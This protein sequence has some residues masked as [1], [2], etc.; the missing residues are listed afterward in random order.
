MPIIFKTEILFFTTKHFF[1]FL[2][3]KQIVLPSSQA[4]FIYSN[5][6]HTH[7]CL[8]VHLPA[9]TLGFVM[10]KE[11]LRDSKLSVLPPIWKCI[12]GTQ[13]TVFL[14]RYS[15]SQII[16]WGLK[17]SHMGK[18]DLVLEPSI[19]NCVVLLWSL[20]NQAK[21]PYWEPTV[22]KAGCCGSHQDRIPS[23]ALSLT[24]YHEG[25]PYLHT[26]SVYAPLKQ[27]TWTYCPRGVNFPALVG[28]SPATSQRD[29]WLILEVKQVKATTP[30]HGCKHWSCP[31]STQ[32]S[33]QRSKR[34]LGVTFFRVQWLFFP[35]T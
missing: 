20:F 15:F 1:K 27:G 35:S 22:G 13:K 8:H 7:T 24:S 30:S 4:I 16:L 12:A 18:K 10:L 2:E 3:L 9:W 26:V 31:P 23:P 6:E 19:V 29:P 21:H 14:H 11:E 28:S 34:G 25:A 5:M 32:P 17:I 33:L